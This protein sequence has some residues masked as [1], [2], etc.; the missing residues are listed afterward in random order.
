M[1]FGANKCAAFEDVVYRGTCMREK[2]EHPTWLSLGRLACSRSGATPTL[3][4][5]SDS[6]FET[7]N[8]LVTMQRDSSGHVRSAVRASISVFFFF[9]DD[10]FEKFAS[11]VPYRISSTLEIQRENSGS[12]RIPHAACKQAPARAPPPVSAKTGLR[13]QASPAQ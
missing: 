11:F 4:M 13:Q 6:G 9:E 7:S 10:P 5:W 12:T 2:H 1:H 8:L 3:S